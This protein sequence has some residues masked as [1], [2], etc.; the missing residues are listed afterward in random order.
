M[1]RQVNIRITN[2]AAAPYVDVRSLCARI[3]PTDITVT[4]SAHRGKN[5]FRWR[6]PPLVPLE[7]S[8][9]VED[10][11]QSFVEEIRSK[12]TR[13]CRSDFEPR[14]LIPRLAKRRNLLQ[15][16]CLSLVMTLR[17]RLRQLRL[18]GLYTGANDTGS[19]GFFEGYQLVRYITMSQHTGRSC[20]A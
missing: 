9:G 12:I 2:L 13:E 6:L 5:V 17:G 8:C 10:H 4:V 11:V 14:V 20:I 1:N 15:Y 7:I 16:A 18:G 3:G 19:S